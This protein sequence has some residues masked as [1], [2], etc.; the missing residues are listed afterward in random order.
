MQ[1]QSKN[2]HGVQYPLNNLHSLLILNFQSLGISSYPV[3]H[4]VYETFYYMKSF[5]DFNFYRHQAVARVWAELARNLADSVILPMNCTDYAIKIHGSMESVK[6][7]Y[8]DRM[9]QEGISFG[10]NW[11]IDI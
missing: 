9:N 11:S 10:K 3:Y 5:L 6:D 8:E 2:W 1:K 4:S 7:A